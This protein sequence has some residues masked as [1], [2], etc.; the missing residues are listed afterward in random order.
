MFAS[1]TWRLTFRYSTTVLQAWT[2]YIPIV[3]A[4]YSRLYV[5]CTVLV[6]IGR[7]A[8]GTK[9]LDVRKRAQ[10]ASHFSMDARLTEDCHLV[11]IW[12]IIKTPAMC[13]HGA[14][15][16]TK[17]WLVNTAL[18]HLNGMHGVLSITEAQATHY[19]HHGHS[20]TQVCLSITGFLSC[21]HFYLRLPP[22]QTPHGLQPLCLTLFLVA[23][24]Q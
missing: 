23:W 6:H 15:Q 17:L 12:K 22:E 20:K 8:N 10:N 7:A 1:T 2:S 21:V 9:S 11:T 16:P 19:Q 4:T 18:A 24:P 5:H 14:P 13:S 3:T